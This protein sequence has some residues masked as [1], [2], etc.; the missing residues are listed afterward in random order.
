METKTKTLDDVNLDMIKLLN[1]SNYLELYKLAG[2]SDLLEQELS[3]ISIKINSERKG[4]ITVHTGNITRANAR[5]AIV[6]NGM[7]HIG[8][9]T[10]YVVTKCWYFNSRD[11]TQ[12]YNMHGVYY[13]PFRWEDM[14]HYNYNGVDFWELKKDHV[15]AGYSVSYEFYREIGNTRT[16]W[17]VAIQPDLLNNFIYELK[18]IFCK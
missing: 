4:S 7:L 9:N 3:V 13:V 16:D 12:P 14:K 18:K 11:E 10:N 15:S 2:N 5:E 6:G 8:E 17:M 1:K